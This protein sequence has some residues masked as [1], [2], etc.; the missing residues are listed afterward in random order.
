MV[1][2][3]HTI[4][5]GRWSML[6][7][8]CGRMIL[9]RYMIHITITH[10]AQPTTTTTHHPSIQSIHPS[11]PH[12][13]I[14]TYK[15]HRHTKERTKGHQPHTVC[16]YMNTIIYIIPAQHPSTTHTPI[17]NIS[18]STPSFVWIH[19]RPSLHRLHPI[20]FHTSEIRKKCS[21]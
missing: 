7:S 20:Q 13:T 3:H 16:I 17:D 8:C 19:S 11:N 4:K 14:H 21:G 18:L 9:S 5:E 12:T 15:H 6:W 2:H 1:T 10:N